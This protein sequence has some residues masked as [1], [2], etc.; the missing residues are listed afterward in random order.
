MAIG[1]SFDDE[2]D[3]EELAEMLNAAVDEVDAVVSSLSEAMGN[4]P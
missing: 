2:I 1:M 3:T 4:R